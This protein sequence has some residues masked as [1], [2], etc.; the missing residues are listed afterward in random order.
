MR[1]NDRLVIIHV[2]DDSKTYLAPELRSDYIYQTTES[3]LLPYLR[4]DQYSLAWVAKSRHKTTRKQI[5]ET[6]KFQGIDLMVVGYH[7][8]RGP[9]E[10]Q[11][12]MGSAVDLSLQ[13]GSFSLLIVK[14]PVS[15]TELHGSFNWVILTDGSSK[16]AQSFTIAAS[17]MRKRDCLYVIH[18]RVDP[19]DTLRPHYDSQFTSHGVRGTYLD[20]DIRRQTFIEELIDFLN[21][22]EVRVDITVVGV[23]GNTA[24]E[25]GATHVGSVTFD[26]IKH[27]KSNILVIK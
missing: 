14:N 23:H 17:M 4:P 6:A 13:E 8:R 3:Q 16:A 15:R 11:T 1:E 25:T 26:I 5:L 22:W 7:G 27:V 12:V 21:N 24:S 20:I 2:F 18:G 19:S 10:D 9:K